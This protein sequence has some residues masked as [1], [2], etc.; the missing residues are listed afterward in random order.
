MSRRE[1]GGYRW[2]EMASEERLWD[3]GASP[4]PQVNCLG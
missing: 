2:E 4:L 3:I 1:R